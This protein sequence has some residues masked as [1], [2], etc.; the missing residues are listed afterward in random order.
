MSI[1]FEMKT[2][3]EYEKK[4]KLY[5]KFVIISLINEKIDFNSDN[6]S[7]EHLLFYIFSCII[8]IVNMI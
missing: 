5:I 2:K 8:R 1:N 3:G 4:S 7:S 6:S